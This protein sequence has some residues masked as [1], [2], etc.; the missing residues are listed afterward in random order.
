MDDFSTVGN[1]IGLDARGNV[2][3]VGTNSG[4][5]PTTPGAFQPTFNGGTRDAVVVK[6]GSTFPDTIGVFRPPAAVRP[7]DP[8]RLRNSNTA[9]A[10]DLTVDFGQA[11]DQPLAGDWNGDGVDDVG[12]FRPSTAQFLLRQ[13]VRGPFGVIINTT[14]TI[15]FGLTGDQ[16][17][18]GDWNGDG[19]DTPGVF[20]NGQWLLTN[21]PNTGG[22]TPPIDLIFNF[23]QAGDKP[24]AGDWNG[25]GIDTIGVY[26]DTPQFGS[27]LLSNTNPASSIDVALQLGVFASDLPVTGDWDGDGTDNP[28]VFRGSANTFFLNV[29]NVNLDNFNFISSFTAPGDI[30]IAGDWDGKPG[31][32]PPNSGVNNP[33][34]GSSAV[35]QTQVFTTTC[36]DPDG[37][38]DISTI[39]F[40]IARS[41]VNGQGVP[42]ALWAQFDENQNLIRLYDPDLQTWREGA[43]GSNLVLDNGYVQLNLAGTSVQ[44]S[45]PLGPSVQI[46]WEVVFKNPAT[47]K[48]YKQY[49][50]ITDDAGSSTG[51]ENV[52]SWSVL[53]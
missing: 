21:G 33:S 23:G 31:N 49:L 13:P 25:D 47:G 36:S 43:P 14:I 34:E 12:V 24:V 1:G 40:K 9:G 4:S 7:V 42:I 22:S 27:F 19:I 39:D 38:H 45:G 5:M 2:Y 15:N 18:V 35:G 41:K 48:N 8:F 29:N 3:V 28:G 26:R 51:F 32:T 16:G 44:G 10:P 17:V 52:G 20:R 53:K 46:R 6:I 37:W 30:P 50:K 11:G